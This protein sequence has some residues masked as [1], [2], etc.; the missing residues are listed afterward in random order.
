MLTAA[1]LATAVLAAP[2]PAERILNPAGKVGPYRLGATTEQQIVAG[3]GTPLQV[4]DDVGGV[5]LLRYKVGEFFTWFQISTLAAFRTES[6]TWRTNRGTRVGMTLAQARRRERARVR[7]GA[8]CV[9]QAIIRRNA[10]RKTRLFVGLAGGRVT[11]LHVGPED[12]YPSPC[13]AP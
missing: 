5:R 1:L 9:D 12:G 10:K 7:P 13:V 4:V 6:R 3:L 11:L 2:P 8:G